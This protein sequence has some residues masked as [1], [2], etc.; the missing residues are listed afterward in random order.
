VIPYKIPS[1]PIFGWELMFCLRSIE[2]NFKEDFDITIIGECPDYIDQTKVNFIE[3]NPEFENAFSV[4]NSHYYV[5]AKHFDNFLVFHDDM[6]VVDECSLD[7]FLEPKFIE[8]VNNFNFSDEETKTLDEF[9][10]RMRAAYKEL[11]D[12]NLNYMK[13]F[14]AH[15][16][17]FVETS[18]LL[19]LKHSIDVVEKQLPFDYFY[20]NFFEYEGEP[21]SN[22]KS[23]HYQLRDTKINNKAKILN[24]DELGYIYQPWIINVLYR[25]FIEPSSFE[26]ENYVQNS[27]T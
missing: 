10:K 5:A 20:F 8:I 19:K 25:L 23:G 16:P 12:N 4:V 14:C 27:T 18:K 15:Y 21:I 13:N 17:F 24:H 11:R 26:K 22:L 2:K 6:Y 3:H 9:Q 1:N 7:D